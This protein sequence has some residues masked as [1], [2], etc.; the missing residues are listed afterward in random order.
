MDTKAPKPIKRT[1]L[2]LWLKEKAPE[3]AEAVGD[4]LPDA[5]ALGIVRRLLDKYASAEVASEGE[6]YIL[7]AEKETEV[8][9]RWELDSGHDLSRSVRPLIV[10]GTCITFL[11]FAVLDSINVL[12][13]KAAYINLLESLLYTSV[14]GY[15][16]LRSADKFTARKG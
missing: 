4:V 2:G 13:I 14:G 11:L 7:R 6:A 10:L 1:P 5:G 9:K 15:F 16:V 12:V 3:V 8:T